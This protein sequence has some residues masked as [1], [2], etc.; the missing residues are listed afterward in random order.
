LERVLSIVMVPKDAAADAE[1]QRTVTV[2]E[3]RECRFIARG[4]EPL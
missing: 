1:H 3:G 2:Y 4:T